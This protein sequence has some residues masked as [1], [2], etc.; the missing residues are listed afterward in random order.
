[1]V[2]QS[3]VI[4]M[5]VIQKAE[6]TKIDS[7]FITDFIVRW[8]TSHQM[9]ERFYNMK[10]IMDEIPCNPQLINGINR[11]QE[12]KLKSL[13]LTSEDWEMIA[14]LKKLLKPFYISTKMLQGRKYETLALSK[15][16]IISYIKLIN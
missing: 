11:K 6:L 3:N 4:N 16:K 8:S 9:L 2:K 15:V 1:M 12:N 14:M 13:I 7:N 5:H 10:V